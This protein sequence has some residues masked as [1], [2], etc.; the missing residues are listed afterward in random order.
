MIALYGYLNCGVIDMAV[1]SS[2]PKV[3][4]D[5]KALRAKEKQLKKSI[6]DL[7]PLVMEILQIS[8]FDDIKLVKKTR[9]DVD[10]KLALAL[11]KSLV[12]KGRLT[13]EHLNNLY[14]SV[15]DPNAFFKLVKG[16]KIKKADV[17]K[18]TITRKVTKE[19]RVSHK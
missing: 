19:I 5:F 8:D 13:D 15:F 6:E 10:A 11:V 1:A 16:G 3:L 7:K 4:D 9:Y 18:G 12:D 17:T 2:R 14:V